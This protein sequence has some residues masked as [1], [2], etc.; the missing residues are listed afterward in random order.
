MLVLFAVNL[1]NKERILK[2][3]RSKSQ[4]T[5]NSKF[6]KIT[7]DFSTD[8]LKPRRAWSEVF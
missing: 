3:V 7:T 2:G 4:I 1:E 8:T 5:Y 6:L